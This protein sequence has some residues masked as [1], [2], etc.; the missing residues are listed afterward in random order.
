[1]LCGNIQAPFAHSQTGL[2]IILFTGRNRLQVK[3][4]N[5]HAKKLKKAIISFRSNKKEVPLKS[6]EGFIH[7]SLQLSKQCLFLRYIHR[8]QQHLD[9]T[10]QCK[11]LEYTDSLRTI[12]TQVHKQG[13]ISITWYYEPGHR[14]RLSCFS[15]T[16]ITFCRLWLHSYLILSDGDH[17]DSMIGMISQGIQGCTK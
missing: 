10:H 14:R 8:G 7:R 5:E 9:I 16:F 17:D 11:E 13:L 1:M 6:P 3:Q 4:K 12:N 2:E 15:S